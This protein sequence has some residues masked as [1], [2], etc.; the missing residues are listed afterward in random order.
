MT[1]MSFTVTFDD[2]DMHTLEEALTHY[3]LLCEREI[4]KG[5]TAP[6]IADKGTIELIRSKLDAALLKGV[7]DHELWVR[8]LEDSLAHSEGRSGAGRTKRVLPRASRTDKRGGK[9]KPT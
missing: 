7:R 8:S 1:S 3:L 2:S 5:R 6:F 9:R 4:A